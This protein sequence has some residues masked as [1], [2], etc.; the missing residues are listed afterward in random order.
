MAAA[1][2]NGQRA[3]DGDTPAVIAERALIGGPLVEPESFDLLRKVIDAG[4]LADR[5][6]RALFMAY[7]QLADGGRAI[8]P[9]ALADVLDGLEAVG[10]QSHLRALAG[11]Y[12]SS[13]LFPRH[14]DVVKAARRRERWELV[15]TE[16]ARQVADPSDDLEGFPETLATFADEVAG[17][18]GAGAEADRSP[19]QSLSI[20]GIEDIFGLPMEDR[21]ILGD[22]LLAPGAALGV[23]G[24]GGIGK[25]R[26]ALQ[27]AVET[28]RG[29]PFCDTIPTGARNS[30]WLFLQTENGPRRLAH[31][32]AS[33]LRGV[34]GA[35]R[36]R[37]AAQLR[38]L[39]PMKDADRWVSFA[40]PGAVARLTRAVRDF[41]PDVVV[42]DPLIDFFGGDSEN[43]SIQMRECF[44]MACRVA[45]AGN[46]DAAVTIVHHSRTGK[47]ASSAAVGWDRG[48]FARGSKALHASVRAALNI[49]PGAEDD[50]GLLVLACGKSNDSR[51]FDPFAVRLDEGAMSYRPNPE[52]DLEAWREAV[53][54]SGRPGRKPIFPAQVVNI[55]RGAG[56]SM[57]RPDLT[58]ALMET[59]G[60]G[61]SSAYSAIRGALEAGA[62]IEDK[63]Q[64]SISTP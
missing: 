16:L 12:L 33:M 18:V 15:L 26:L 14:A 60:R 10:G 59:T 35:E 50:P 57:R 20:L 24:Q 49:V 37:V 63:E 47:A 6:H 58:H 48:T 32:L 56:G 30:K 4:D 62:I 3:A 19:A 28:I 21:S 54:G 51:P 52:F 29:V 34:T 44:A 42:F 9:V 38:I 25:S 53:S 5:R 39:T 2:T 45:R 27:L 43:D 7:C 40:D 61:R 22:N 8:D 17:G 41:G 13:D 31:D 1:T 46:P 55:L 36:Y 23:F 11:D 64:C